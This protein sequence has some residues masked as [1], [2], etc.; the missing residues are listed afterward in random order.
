MTTRAATEQVIPPES[1]TRGPSDGASVRRARR[2]GAA[3]PDADVDIPRLFRRLRRDVSGEVRFDDSARHLYAE[4]ASNYR[5]V[6]LGVVVPRHVDDVLLTLAACR[7]ANAPV[8]SRTGGTALA[9]Q[10][11]NE[12]VVV[13]F[14]KYMDHILELDPEA[15]RARVE[16]GVVCDR[17]VEA[18][19]P[20][21]L[22]WGPKPATHD[23]C[24]FGGMIANNCGGMHAQYAG[25]AVHNVEALD[26]VLY[27]GTRLSLGWLTLQE[28]ERRAL[29]GGR[30]GEIFARLRELGMRHGE[31]IQRRFPRLPRRVSGYNLDELLPGADG[32]VNLARALVG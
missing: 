2:A 17:L 13:D 24:C 16:P 18:A 7:E 28:W 4:D 15:R 11:A 23:H 26:V 32:R 3:H 9:G 29:G 8:V 21:G 27:D 6:P 20:H 14:S 10:A 12:A 25:I 5:H 31:Q 22:T 1:L 30:E 19:R